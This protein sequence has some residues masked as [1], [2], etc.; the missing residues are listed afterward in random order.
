MRGILFVFALILLAGGASAQDHSISEF[1]AAKTHLQSELDTAKS[2]KLSAE[3]NLNTRRS[4]MET[5][6]ANHKAKE[7]AFL[8]AQDN[9]WKAV[10]DYDEKVEIR[11]QRDE[12]LDAATSALDAAMDQRDGCAGYSPSGLTAG[13]CIECIDES[14]EC[15]PLSSPS[16]W[17]SCSCNPKRDMYRAKYD[18]ELQFTRDVQF[19]LA[20]PETI[21]TY[22]EITEAKTYVDALE[23]ELSAN[24][25]AVDTEQSRHDAYIAE[26]QAA[27]D[28]A[29]FALT[30]L[31][32]AQEQEAS[33]LAVRDSALTTLNNAKDDLEETGAELKIAVSV[34]NGA[35]I[36]YDAAQAT[37][38]GVLRQWREKIESVKETLAAQDASAGLSLQFDGL[39]GYLEVPTV[40]LRTEFAIESWIYF[41][42]VRSDRRNLPVIAQARTEGGDL[43]KFVFVLRLRGGPSAEEESANPDYQYYYWD[44]KMGSPSSPGYAVEMQSNP[45][46]PSGWMH[47][48]I[49]VEDLGPKYNAKFYI[50]GDLHFT[51][52]FSA[53]RWSSKLP[54]T[55]MK[56][57]DS[58]GIHYGSGRIDELRIWNGKRTA[59]EIRDNMHISMNG[60]QQP[61]RSYYK[62]NEDQT[63]PE[64]VPDVVRDW[65][66]MRLDGKLHYPPSH[67]VKYVRSGVFE[68]TGSAARSSEYAL[69]FN[70]T[71]ELQN[72][73]EVPAF[74]MSG[75]FTV[76]F[77]F[78]FDLDYDD[79][80]RLP[81][82]SQSVR[83]GTTRERFVF[84]MELH[85][86]PEG[87][88][89][90]YTD[91]YW[92]F[93]MGDCAEET[94]QEDCSYL[95]ELRG[96]RFMPDGW[97]HV[98]VTVSRNSIAY[99][100]TN[101]DCV[102]TAQCRAQIPPEQDQRLVSTRPITIGRLVD[103]LGYHGMTGAIDELRLWT[104][105]RDRENVHAFM[106]RTPTE[107][108]TESSI[109]NRT[110][111]A[112]YRFDESETETTI[113][114]GT[115]RLPAEIATGEDWYRHGKLVG[116]RKRMV[117]T[118]LDEINLSSRVY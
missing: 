118:A 47:V 74:D 38:E 27:K 40:N 91:M 106:A 82:I 62:F 51:R 48:A 101:G 15:G 7:E 56:Y 4:E 113:F 99:I 105:N 35:Q 6:Q 13:M 98:A 42:P 107:A 63:L 24:R 69:Y 18:A 34:Y 73:V 109:H 33:A 116:P 84:V 86:Y 72:Y 21:Q 79:K 57:H 108:V 70:S 17:S 67:P 85:G 66:D 39:G 89:E 26:L 64:Y 103:E 110:L 104:V 37:Y 87:D 80:T 9:Y 53:D 112:Y 115:R 32:Q 31:G 52:G 97:G 8:V 36:D 81:L 20:Y 30:G 29:T 78:N 94:P 93:K 92:S 25:T 10:K 16:S 46:R 19:S 45:I 65:S 96:D 54:I 43:N 23:S 59:E 3:S 14:Y 102:D 77:A 61:L 75:D 41:D 50:N 5:K 1:A 22:E 88:P 44:F 117:T 111:S 68:A 58:K 83:D 90:S 76:E 49:S 11:K 100:Y 55:I 114:D 12:E 95:Y 60:W 2:T 71:S 28:A